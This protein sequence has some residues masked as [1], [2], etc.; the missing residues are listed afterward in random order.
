MAV[1]VRAIAVGLVAV[2]TAAC[3]GGGGDDEA[4]T[5]APEDTTEDTNAAEPVTEALDA[6]VSFAGFVIALDEVELTPGE[7]DIGA[8]GVTVTGTAENVGA[9]NANVPQS[10]VF[11]DRDGEV[12]EVDFAQSELPEVPGESTGEVTYAFTIAD[13]EFDLD[14]AVLTFGESGTTQSLVPLDGEGDVVANA[15][16]EIEVTGTV[17]A[18][19]TQFLIEGA[20]ARF[21]R[22]DTHEQAEDGKAFFYL[23]YA[24]TNSSDFAGGYAFVADDTRLETPGGLG[25]APVEFP[26]ELLQPSASLPDLVTI[27]EIDADE[28]GTFTFIGLRNPGTDT[29]VK[30]ELEIEVPEL[31]PAG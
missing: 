7:G 24:V 19:E 1:R 4:T 16:V 3:G 30:G 29:E 10:E 13:D 11:I 20:E 9:E 17:T 27:W 22:P 15:P 18:G 23:R 8:A 6:E 31:L 25:L 5:T 28:P 14:G 26:I 2:L 21:D 12:Y